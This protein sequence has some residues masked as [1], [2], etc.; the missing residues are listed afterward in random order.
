MILSFLRSKAQ[1]IFAFHAPGNVSNQLFAVETSRSGR[2]GGTNRWYGGH[3]NIFSRGAWHFERC[4][5]ECSGG[6]PEDLMVLD[7]LL[8]VIRD[9]WGLQRSLGD[10]METLS[11]GFSRFCCMGIFEDSLGF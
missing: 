4:F 5:Q 2:H 7:E 1:R 6:I 9:S 3:H 10:F 11:R 8:G